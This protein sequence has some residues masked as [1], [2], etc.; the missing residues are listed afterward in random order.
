MISP[1]IP[2]TAT[3]SVLRWRQSSAKGVTRRRND[4]TTEAAQPQQGGRTRGGAKQGPLTPLIAGPGERG[5]RVVPR[6]TSEVTKP[7]NLACGTG[8]VCAGELNVGQSGKGAHRRVLVTGDTAN[9]V[10]ASC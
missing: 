7:S 6:I 2:T 5:R 1:D 3:R 8:S 9:M 10:D 4:G